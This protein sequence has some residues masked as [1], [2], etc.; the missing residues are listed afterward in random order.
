MKNILIIGNGFDI[1]HGLKTS[2]KDFVSFCKCIKHVYE[3]LDPYIFKKIPLA[4]RLVSEKDKLRELFEDEDLP[5]YMLENFIEYLNSDSEES[6]KEK[7]IKECTKNYWLLY[8]Y[9]KKDSLDD[10]WCNL[11]FL[12]GQH[13]EALSFISNNPLVMSQSDKNLD[14]NSIVFKK[15]FEYIK[16]VEKFIKKRNEN[17]FIK[18]INRQKEEMISALNNLTFLLELYLTYFI[19][20]KK[21][22]KELFNKLKITHILSFN[23]TNTYFENYDSS[24]IQRHFIHGEAIKSRSIEE[25]NMVFGIGQEIKNSINEDALDYVMFQ[26]YY[27]RIIKKTGNDYKQWLRG[28]EKINVYI[29]GHSLDV[30]DGDVIKSFV[31]CK[32]TRIIYIFYLNQ[33]ALNEIVINLIG[34]FSKDEVIRLTNE[35]K[36]EFVQ[37]NDSKKIE[38]IIRDNSISQRVNY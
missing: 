10:K 23:Y 17:I 24:N 31:E 4:K 14:E 6:T 38:K 32:H 20:M 27:Q 8:I 19:N 15:N 1:E 16:Y 30:P 34:T 37:S 12:I 11:E 7:F 13:I 5:L 9:E 3:N 26:K 2:Y 33:K 25:N 28:N 21:N 18:Q 22:P 36:I 29:F 35:G